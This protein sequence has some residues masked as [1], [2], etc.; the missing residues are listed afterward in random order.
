MHKSV[1]TI[2][3][4]G[5]FSYSSVAKAYILITTNSKFPDGRLINI[6]E[7]DKISRKLSKNYNTLINNVCNEAKIK[8]IILELLNKLD[9]I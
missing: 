9:C 2:Q 1:D 8:I 3:E 5:A 7:L 6:M 4:S